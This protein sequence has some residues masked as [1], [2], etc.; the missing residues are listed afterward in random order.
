MTRSVDLA[1]VG[2]GVVGLAH[3]YLAARHGLTVAV[4]DR[5][6][7]A[8]GASVRNF[9]FITVTGQGKPDTWRRAR[10]SRDV[11]TE[12]AGAA[13]IPVLHR[14]LVLAVHSA[15]ARRVIDEFAAGPMGEGCVVLEPDAARRR[16]PY[17][18]GAD[19]AG[20]LHSPHELRV[21][22]RTAIPRLAAWLA[23]AH[24]VTFVRPAA[25]TAVEPGRIRSSAG[26][27]LARHIV[28]CPGHDYRTL[29]PG[30]FAGRGLQECKLHMLRLSDPGW[31]LSAAVMSD[32]GLVRYRGYHDCPSQPGLVAELG[33]TAASALAD[34]IHL[35]VVQ[36]A[37][38]SLVVGDSHHYAPTV[39]DFA[40]DSVDDGI[41]ALARRVLD[42]AHCRVVERWVGVYGSG[43][44]DALIERVDERIAVVA[45]TS[46]TG[47]STAFGLAQDCLEML[48][49]L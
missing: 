38:G 28:V 6:H 44:E 40:P 29:F 18:A 49:L 15:T 43:A 39:D 48:G 24:N 9:G 45:V 13:G 36:S 11:W 1:I 5:D 37:D 47:A 4:L 25:V 17:L 8:N 21:E 19:L 27:I 10:V 33:R 22:S 34:G 20:A 7:V 31:R 41:L 16:H 32:L 42:L 35:I 12:I 3:A 2:A 14:G 46:G 30:V 23:E 26:E